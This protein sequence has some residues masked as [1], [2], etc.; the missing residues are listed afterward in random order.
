MVQDRHIT[1]NLN[2]SLER[3]GTFYS[4]FSPIYLSS[5]THGGED[6]PVYANGPSS[7]LF[8]GV[9]DHNYIAH[10]ISHAACI[11]PH[12]TICNERG[13]AAT[14]FLSYSVYKVK[15]S[16]CLTN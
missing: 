8:S 12:A 9:Y 1:E 6:V 3:N 16:P 14:V 5:D 4:H 13:G 7:N 2:S 15:L 10:T 11:G